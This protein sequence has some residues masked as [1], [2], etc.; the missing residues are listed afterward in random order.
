MQNLLHLMQECVRVRRVERG[1]DG[2]DDGTDE[3]ADE[4]Q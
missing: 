2:V 1:R 3:I 4:A